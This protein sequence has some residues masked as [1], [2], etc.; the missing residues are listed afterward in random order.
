MPG[1]APSITCAQAHSLLYSLSRQTQSLSFI[2]LCFHNLT[3]SSLRLF[4]LVLTL[5]LQLNL[6]A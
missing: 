4:R 6:L 5:D 3:I 1:G 2:T